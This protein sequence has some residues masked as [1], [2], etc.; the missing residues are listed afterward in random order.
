MIMAQSTFRVKI[1]WN[2]KENEKNKSIDYIFGR[3]IKRLA[4]PGRHSLVLAC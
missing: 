4:V 3:K 2:L 1:D